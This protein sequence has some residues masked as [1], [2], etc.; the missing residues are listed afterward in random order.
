MNKM[1]NKITALVLMCFN[2]LLFISCKQNSYKKMD[3][4]VY[5]TWS[6][7]ATMK[8]E[9]KEMKDADF[10]TF[11]TIKNK[12]NIALAKDKNHVYKEDKIIEN[13]DPKTFEPLKQRFWKDKNHVYFLRVYGNECIIN[14]ADPKTFVVVRDSWT[15]DKTNAFYIYD[16]LK[17]VDFQT[18][19]PIDKDWAKDKQTYY[20]QNFKVG[21]LD[22]K[23]AEIISP[24]YIK[25]NKNVFF[26]NKIV[27]GANP[28]TFVAD[29]FS[30]FGQ[31]DKNKFYNERN[32]GSISN[33]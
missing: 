3:G 9:N 25:D 22:F 16:K 15:K 12:E 32:D 28:Q 20:Y 30:G 26:Q 2:A 24:Y 17:E 10:S 6:S 5:F 4:K 7:G 1:K 27:N 23:S 18:F 13:A 19:T 8:M 33:K 11:E 29:K 14:D 21:G 31:D